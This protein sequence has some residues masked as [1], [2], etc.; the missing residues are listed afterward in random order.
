MLLDHW[1][2][3]V[4]NYKYCSDYRGGSSDICG[5]IKPYDESGNN[6][7]KYFK[8]KIMNTNTGCEKVPKDC[9]DV[10]A[11]PI[12]CAEINP[13]IK[14][15]R[16]KHCVF[17]GNQCKTYFK[18]CE[19]VVNLS[20][21]RTKCTGNII[22]NYITNE[23]KDDD[24]DSDKCVRK[25]DC[26]EFSFTSYDELCKSINPIC[27]YNYINDEC[28]T[29]SLSCED[30]KFYPGSPGSE[31]LCNSIDIEEPY[32]IC[33]LKEDK[34]GCEKKYRETFYPTVGPIEQEET[35][36]P[37]SS[38]FIKGINLIIILLC[39]LF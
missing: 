31:E 5:K 7:D 8:C 9:E 18:N 12:L 28:Y 37:S 33:S 6:L 39:L 2:H 32:K 26:S 4:E 25:K 14:D 13:N 36:T 35:N 38:G 34:S 16:V 29:S 20:G 1:S 17:Y 30:I 19:N 23:C 3:C 11:N 15:N 24:T 21:D 10:G 27:K 22:E